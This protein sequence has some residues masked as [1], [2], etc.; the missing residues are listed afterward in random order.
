MAAIE[1]GMDGDWHIWFDP[2]T[3]YYNGLRGEIH[4]RALDG[5]YVFSGNW[6][7]NKGRPN[8]TEQLADYE[9]VMKYLQT[10][11]P[12]LYPDVRREDL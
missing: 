3:G 4:A 6:N 11:Q 12:L 10:R 5:K 9:V 7:I 2:K 1:I 8:D